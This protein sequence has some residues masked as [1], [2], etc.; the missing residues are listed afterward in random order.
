MAGGGERAETR[1]GGLLSLGT[2][3]VAAT[4]LTGIVAVYMALVAFGNITDFDTN[5]QCV[6]HVLAMDT[7]FEDP[8]L[9]WRAIESTALQDAAYVAIIVWE[10]LTALVLLAATWLWA[11]GLRGGDH[12]RARRA[13]T[14]GLVMVLLL[15]GL[16]FFAIGGEW[17]AMWQSSDWNGLD[18]AARNVML[19]AFALVVVN[20]PARRG[21]DRRTD[22]T[23]LAKAVDE[24]R[25]V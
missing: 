14:R 12:G 24:E 8:D 4:V 11:V 9:M 5:R 7:T 18:A 19:A 6:R 17:C 25:A 13:A 23:P 10:T 1:T 22:G 21:N 3:P 20:L 15:F 2:P 16:G